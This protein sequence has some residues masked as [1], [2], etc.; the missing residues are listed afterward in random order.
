MRGSFCYKDSE[1]SIWYDKQVFNMQLKKHWQIAS[2]VYG[3]GSET[4]INTD[5][6]I[7]QTDARWAW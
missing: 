3:T 6:K 2:L 5:K 7:K 1:M 4:K